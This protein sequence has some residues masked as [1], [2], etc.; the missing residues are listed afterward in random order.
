MKRMAEVEEKYEDICFAIALAMKKDA[1]TVTSIT[2]KQ[3]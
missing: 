1:Q 2:F 3:N